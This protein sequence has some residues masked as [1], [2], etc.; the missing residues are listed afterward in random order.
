MRGRDYRRR[1]N[2]KKERRLKTIL[3]T[4]CRVPR[5]GYV[6]CDWVEGEWKPVGKYIKRPKNSHKQKF[7]KRE[8]RRLVRRSEPFPNGNS[9]R[10]CMEYRWHYRTVCFCMAFPVLVRALWRSA[11]LRLAEERLLYAERISQMATLLMKS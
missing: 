8:S 5:A 2:A 1:M 10:K 11:S 9:Y 7:L 4:Y 3:T 6:E